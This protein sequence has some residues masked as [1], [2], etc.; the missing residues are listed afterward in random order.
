MA[1]SSLRCLLLNSEN[2]KSRFGPECVVRQDDAF[3]SGTLQLPQH[4]DVKQALGF[5]SIARHGIEWQGARFGD[6]TPFL[7]YWHALDVWR[8]ITVRR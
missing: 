6:A 2:V 1:P 5:V 4:L 7:G 8:V 3:S